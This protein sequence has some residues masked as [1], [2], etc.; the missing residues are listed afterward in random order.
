MHTKCFSTCP[1]PCEGLRPTRLGI[2]SSV[3][4]TWFEAGELRAPCR[5]RLS[6][7]SLPY[8]ALP[9]LSATD[10]QMPVAFWQVHKTVLGA[11]SL[12]DLPWQGELPGGSLA[13]WL[14]PLATAQSDLTQV[15]TYLP[16]HWRKDEHSMW[17]SPPTQD[18]HPRTH[19]TFPL[20][21]P[22][23]CLA[24]SSCLTTE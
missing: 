7:N 20:A 1:C 22:A 8:E 2:S 13:G 12:L 24:H 19:A 16:N 5:A 17:L 6:G 21:L 10:A 14:L 4:L 3:C 23:G 18:T 9:L 15:C 11:Y